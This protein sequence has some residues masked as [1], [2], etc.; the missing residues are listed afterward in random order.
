MTVKKFII[1]LII[2]F[3]VPVLMIWLKDYHE[4]VLF[5]AG[6][7]VFFGIWPTVKVL[8]IGIIQIDKSV[9]FHFNTKLIQFL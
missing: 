4:G 7:I 5:W 6:V 3:T 1:E 2:F 8:M 9:I